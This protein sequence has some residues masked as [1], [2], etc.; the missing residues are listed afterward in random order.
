MMPPELSRALIIKG[1]RTASPETLRQQAALSLA[2]IR[3]RAKAAG[4]LTPVG[5]H[6]WRA[7]PRLALAAFT[8]RLR[9]DG[10]L[11]PLNGVGCSRGR[12]SCHLL[13][14]YQPASKRE[15]GGVCTV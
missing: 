15:R 14:T 1:L 6:T 5:C 4:F 3:K 10:L 7:I 13:K 12:D 11:G 8:K 9:V 2:A